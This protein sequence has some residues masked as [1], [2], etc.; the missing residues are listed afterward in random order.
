MPPH[1]AYIA[2]LASTTTIVGGGLAIALG[3]LEAPDLVTVVL[4]LVAIIAAVTLEL[5]HVGRRLDVAAAPTDLEITATVV[6]FLSTMLVTILMAGPVLDATSR[7]FGRPIEHDLA[8][9]AYTAAALA[10]LGA[11]LAV[12]A[13]AVRPFLPDTAPIGAR[14]VRVV[15]FADPVPAALSSFRALERSATAVSTVFTL[16]ERRAGVWLALLL[17]AG[18]L[19][20]AVR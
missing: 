3:I 4:A 11:I 15:A 2:M 20:W 8:T 7:A 13:G 5:V 12:A 19:F 1:R 16:F 17:I 6:A 14:L 10:V 18:V 9:L